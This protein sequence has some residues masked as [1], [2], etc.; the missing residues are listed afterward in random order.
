MRQIVYTQTGVGDGNAL[1]LDIHGRPEISL[2]VQVGGSA[3]WSLQQTLDNPF[4]TPAG[5]ITW[6]DHPDANMVAQTVN[7][8]GN[9]A[10]VPAAVRVRVTAGTGSAKLT[11]VQAGIIG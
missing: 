4:T 6:F 10:Y 7:R 11:I 2:Q 5:S 1:P 9:Y 3:T 8:Q